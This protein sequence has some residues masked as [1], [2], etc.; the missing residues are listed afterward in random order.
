MTGSSGGRVWCRTASPATPVGEAARAAQVHWFI[1]E[2]ASVVLLTLTVDAG[3]GHLG[4]FGDVL[5]LVVH[6]VGASTVHG[7]RQRVVGVSGESGLD[8]IVRQGIYRVAG[9]SIISDP[10][11]AAGIRTV[12]A[13]A[14]LRPD[15]ANATKGR[16]AEELLFVARDGHSPLHDSF[17]RKAHLKARAAINRPTLRIHDLRKTAAT[18]AAQ[19]GATVRELMKR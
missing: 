7:L 1:S 12:Y 8:H 3:W 13:P 2:P 10:K 17:L 11:T 14:S 16:S 18:L 9:K 15:L 4:A 6:T 19:Q 5:P